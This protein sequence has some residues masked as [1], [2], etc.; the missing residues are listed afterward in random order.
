MTSQEV[1]VTVLK[2]ARTCW[3]MLMH[4]TNEYHYVSIPW[5]IKATV[6]FEK[7]SCISQ[8]E[9]YLREAR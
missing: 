7:V 6:L 2:R 1:K 9:L 5:A 8:I 4:A 3:G